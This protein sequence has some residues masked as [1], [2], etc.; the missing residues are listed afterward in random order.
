MSD[1][2]KDM[3]N[4]DELQSDEDFDGFGNLQEF[5]DFEDLS[6]LSAENIL[7]DME[8]LGDISDLGD[9]SDV[10]DLSEF[11]DITDFEEDMEKASFETMESEVDV[12]SLMQGLMPDED[13]TDFPDG[14]LELDEGLLPDIEPVEVAEADLDVSALFETT[15]P[16]MSED[17]VVLPDDV[18]FSDELISDLEEAVGAMEGASDSD[19]LL[20]SLFETVEPQEEFAQPIVPDVTSAEESLDDMLDD[21]LENLDTNGSLEVTGFDSEESLT[22]ELPEAIQE[23]LAEEL[24]EEG[25]LDDLLGLLAS[26]G[27][28]EIA[29]EDVIGLDEMFTE[30]VQ[31]G[32]IPETVKEDEPE[33]PG[34]L[35]RLFGNVVTEEIAQKE[36]A[37]RE[38]EKEA[39]EQRAEE[40]AKEKEEAEAA[41]ALKAEEKAAK[42][43]AKAEEKALKK[44]EKDAK[45]AE[46]E[47]QAELEVVGKLN[48]VGVSIVVILTALFLTAEITGTQF[49]SYQ[50]TL[51]QAKDYFGMQRYT[52]AYQEIL[53][54]DIKEKDQETYDKIITVMK[55]QRSLN[56]YANYDSMKYY[57]DALNALLRGIEKY[58]DNIETGRN[59]EVEK[60]MDYCREQILAILEEEFGL[61]ESEA[62]DILAMEKEEYTE[63]VVEIGM[64]SK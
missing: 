24:P 10:S 8:E 53:G 23:D 42:K 51:N 17:E 63:K 11:D 36:L 39:Q 46:A 37:D 21:L 57:P 3:N 35:K 41:K 5:V 16:E 61:S 52:Q 27:E 31:E 38:A 7:S 12:A 14:D 56:S 2:E 13:T 6:D 25:G 62:Y 19:A 28:E 26:S 60:D 29:Q 59:L 15:E 33:K 40:A 49:F 22:E 48:K 32:L 43:A 1:L 55:V 9:L 4:A 47:A 54:T 44:A 34:L 30:E 18:D 20:E 50:S 64:N 45:R 58:D